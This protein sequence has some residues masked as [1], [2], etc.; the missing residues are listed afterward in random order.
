MIRASASYRERAVDSLIDNAPIV[1]SG[2]V[3]GKI[4]RPVALMV[5][6]NRFRSSRRCR[7]CVA[8]KR[9]PTDSESV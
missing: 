7:L 3:I 6:G 9:Y 5:G 4:G 2:R 1:G 8:L